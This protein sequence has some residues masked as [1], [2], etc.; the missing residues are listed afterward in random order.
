M[1]MKCRRASGIAKNDDRL[2]QIAHMPDFAATIRVRRGKNLDEK[3]KVIRIPEYL[4]GD[5]LAQHD[6]SQTN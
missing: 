2:E 4:S 5:S 3:F 6:A 1:S